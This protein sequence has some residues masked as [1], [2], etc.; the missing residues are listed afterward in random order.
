VRIAVRDHGPG[1]P[2]AVLPHL[3]EPF[4]TTKPIG[5]GLGLGLAISLA[6]VESFGGQL[7]ARNA[8]GGGA[9]FSVLLDAC[10]KE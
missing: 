1:I 3:F 7:E 6:I 8:E 10:P 5:E 2:E 9:E 4:Y